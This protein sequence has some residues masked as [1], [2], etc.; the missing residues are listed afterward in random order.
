MKYSFFMIETK[1]PESL[2]AD[3]EYQGSFLEH[4]TGTCTIKVT[5]DITVNGDFDGLMKG[6]FFRNLVLKNFLNKKLY[7]KKQDIKEQE[8][9][10]KVW[11][12]KIFVNKYLVVV[13]T[14]GM[15]YTNTKMYNGIYLV[16]K[17]TLDKMKEMEEYLQNENTRRN[18]E[19]S[20]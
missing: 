12:Y 15:R 8:L 16:L 9:K 13:R 11:K 5:N 14:D 4:K 1:N 6:P 19:G 3:I 18:S 2:L 10:I 17:E 7:K 20:K